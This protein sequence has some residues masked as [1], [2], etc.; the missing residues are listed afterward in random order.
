MPI[1]FLILVF[2]NFLSIFKGE[3]LRNL[4]LSD[5]IV[6]LHINDVHCGL[7]DKIG[8]DGFALYRDE[9]K[10]Q[11]KNVI[12][13]DV[14]DHI[15]GDALGAISDGEAIINIVNKVGFDV[16]IL[17]N[18]EFDYSIEQLLYLEKKTSSSHICVNFCYRKNKTAIFEPY[19]IIEAG[20]KKIAF[21]SVLTPLTFSKTYISTL[22]DKDG[23][24]IYDF[25][26]GNNSQELY[27]T[28]QK[29]INKVRN[30]EKVDYVILL[31]HIGMDIEAYTSNGLLSKLEGVDIV[32][33]GHTH[34]IYNITTP[35]KNKKN[36]PISQVGTKLEAVGKIIIKPN[37][38]ITSEIIYEIPEPSDKENATQIFRSKKDRWINKEIQNYI[39]IEWDKYSDILNE[40]IGH[41]NYDLIIRPENKTDNHFIYCRYKECTVGNILADA[42]KDA[43][44]SEI[45]ILNGGSIR[46]NM[47]KG[48]LTKAFIIAIMPWFNN[49]VVKRISGQRILDALEFG[50]SK[51]PESAGAFPQVSGITFDVDASINSSVEVDEYE[52]FKN[53][54]GKRRVSNVKINGE[55]L[56]LKRMYNTSLIE[57]I[58]NGGDGYTMFKEFEVFNE[59]LVTDTDALGKFIS[60]KLKGE[61]PE[62]YK[63]F[64]GRINIHNESN[65]LDNDSMINNN[66]LPEKLLM[67]FDSYE[68][69]EN[70]Y[71]ISFYTHMRLVD[72][73]INDIKN[74]SLK[75]N[76]NYKKRN[77]LRNIEEIEI[78]CENKGKKESSIFSFLCS[79]DVKGEVEEISFIDNSITVNGKNLDYKTND[80]AKITGKNIQNQ[81]DNILSQDTYILENA[82]LTN[83]NN[84]FVIEG[85]NTDGNFKSSNN[86][87][88]LFNDN[89]KLQNASCSLEDENDNK[90]KLICRPKSFID[91]DLR[92]NN[93]VNVVDQ[94]KNLILNFN[95]ELNS[96]ANS[97]IDSN[98]PSTSKK[99]R[100]GLST[101]GIIAIIIPCV[102]VLLAVTALVAVYSKP[103]NKKQNNNIGSFNS[104]NNITSSQNIN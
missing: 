24:P 17:G 10:K 97:T 18:H 30:D 4:E 46:N 43:G 31:T 73:I 26:I 78:N 7:N 75:A 87:Y 15:Q 38:E 61:I 13:V 58:A 103:V 60:D 89:S 6:I 57:Y 20:D 80:I 27:D 79:K 33:D 34:L 8:Y 82:N 54:T 35:D 42:I 21:I 44:N 25:L 101:G 98:Y 102:I 96:I 71:R 74:M 53:I 70:P 37:G 84:K 99:R 95:N 9:L 50:V 81:K 1:N 41:S 51:L 66:T 29:Y 56:D 64:Q 22:F 48:N 2:L 100:K 77:R 90:Y 88:L 19:K 59:S 86:A 92:L 49:I 65:T 91:T 76:I 52:M 11:Y 14:G 16:M 28:V 62:K 40:N 47:P 39:E 85:I 104:S 23:K 68:F 5:D 63:N 69:K 3:H 67:G 32:L 36:I 72:Y 45:T 12:T 55:D 94:K 83:E 93:L